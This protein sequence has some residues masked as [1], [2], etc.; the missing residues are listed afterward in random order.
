MRYRIFWGILINAYNKKN[1]GQITQTRI[2]EL[3]GESKECI[4][5]KSTHP[6]TRKTYD[7]YEMLHNLY[8]KDTIPFENTIEEVKR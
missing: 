1:I 7:K 5:R 8:F 3:Y 6:F 2:A 4:T